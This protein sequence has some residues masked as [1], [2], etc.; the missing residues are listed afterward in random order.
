ML[1][2]VFIHTKYP[3]KYPHK[4]YLASTIIKLNTTPRGSII[5]VRVVPKVSYYLHFTAQFR[6]VKLCAYLNTYFYHS[7]PTN[8]I[9]PKKFILITC[10]HIRILALKYL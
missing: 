4:Y 2:P 7:T 6:Y 10:F 5:N 9:Y 3:H 1:H 8:I